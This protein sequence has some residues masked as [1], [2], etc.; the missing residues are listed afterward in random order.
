[1]KTEM[2]LETPNYYTD[3]KKPNTINIT[4]ELM[5]S[6]K[7]LYRIV[8]AEHNEDLTSL[9]PLPLG[10][11][12]EK[13]IQLLDSKYPDVRHPLNYFVTEEWKDLICVGDREGEYFFDIERVD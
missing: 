4:P 9:G 5:K 8:N 10:E 7:G 3:R 13:M 2:L 12:I 6:A 1:M 11:L